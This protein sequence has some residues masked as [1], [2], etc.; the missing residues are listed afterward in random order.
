[1]AEH[2]LRLDTQRVLIIDDEAE[3][4][5]QLA[6]CLEADGHQVVFHGNIHDAMADACWQV[7]DLIWLDLRLALRMGLDVIPRMLAENPW[8]QIIVLTPHALA[9]A[10]LEAIKRGGD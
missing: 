7:F 8:S 3:N 1:M 4:R 6:L 5:L 2:A 9:D 10:S